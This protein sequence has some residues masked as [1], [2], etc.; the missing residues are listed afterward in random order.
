[1]LASLFLPLVKWTKANKYITV[2]VVEPTDFC[3]YGMDSLFRATNMI[4]CLSEYGIKRYKNVQDKYCL[5]D[6][7]LTSTGKNKFL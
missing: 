6:T 5:L 4:V 3:F 1:M 2:M 7:S